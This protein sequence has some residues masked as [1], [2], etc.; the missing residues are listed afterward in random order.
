VAGKSICFVFDQL[1]IPHPITKQSVLSMTKNANKPLT[2]IQKLSQNTINLLQNQVYK[3]T[4]TCMHKEKRKAP[5]R[6]DMK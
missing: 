3:Y 6:F 2:K 5:P 1:E 4:K